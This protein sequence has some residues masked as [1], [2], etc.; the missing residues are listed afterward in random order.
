MLECAPTGQSMTS[1]RAIVTP[2]G[3]PDAI[4]FAATMM[5]G[6]TPA[7]SMANILPVR[8]MPDC[9]SSTT[10]QHAVLRGYRGEALKELRRGD[11]VPA[12]PL[13]RL[14]DDRRDLVGRHEVREDLIL[15]V[16][17]A[18]AR[19]ARGIALPPTGHRYGFA[20]GA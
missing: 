2:I 19:A 14:D 10:K 20:Y 5:S 16:R 15:D 13:Y 12:F 18:L 7:C 9:T 8:P 3:S 1:S 4:P 6:W 17:E 11:D